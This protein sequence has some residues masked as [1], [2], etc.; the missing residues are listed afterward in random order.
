M[1][2]RTASRAKAPR[3]ESENR[4]Q[5]VVVSSSTGRA[6]VMMIARVAGSIPAA[7]TTEG[8]CSKAASLT[9]NQAERGSIPWAF[10]NYLL[11]SAFR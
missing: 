1:T 2:R 8:Q 4:V 5:P 10:A 11:L 6:A 9:P 7:A 3:C